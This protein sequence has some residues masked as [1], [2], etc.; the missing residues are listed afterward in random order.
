VALSVSISASN[1]PFFTGSP[2]FLCQAAITPSV[3]VSL[4]RGIKITSAIVKFYLSAEIKGKQGK[5]GWSLGLGV[6]RS[7]SVVRRFRTFFSTS[8]IVAFDQQVWY[9]RKFQAVVQ[10]EDEDTMVGFRDN[11]NGMEAECL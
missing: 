5:K 9:L 2:T 3:I 1:S 11:T 7:G 6:L 4:R 8:T 10:K